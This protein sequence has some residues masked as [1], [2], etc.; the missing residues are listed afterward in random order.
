MLGLPGTLPAPDLPPGP[1]LALVAAT[2][3]YSDSGLRQLRAPAQDAAGLAQV[4][5][6][7]GIGGFAVTSVINRTARQL[8]LA[9]EDFLTGRSTEDLL[10]VYLSCHGFVDDRR[11]LHFAATDTR[12]DR[13]GATAV[14]AAVAGLAKLGCEVTLEP[15]QAAWPSS[16]QNPV[17]RMLT[18]AGKVQFP[19][20]VTLGCGIGQRG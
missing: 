15:A 11:Q 16:H 3:R 10:L 17:R 19:R 7:P 6:D 5:S 4:L 9:V 14:Q 13:L 18:P 20:A 2:T 1:R 12:K 8:R